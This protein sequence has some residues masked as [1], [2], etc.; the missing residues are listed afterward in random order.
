MT[1]EFFLEPTPS[2]ASLFKGPGPGLS[3]PPPEP[4][5][6][7]G[8]RCPS[9]NYPP[10]RVIRP[11]PGWHQQNSPLHVPVVTDPLA[12]PRNPA[13]VVRRS[14]EM[15]VYVYAHMALEWHTDEVLFFV[16]LS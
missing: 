5:G 15:C 9:S 14:R 3:S 7:G 10:D 16:L 6:P 12:D 13:D 2:A 4:C 8:G 11:G 1:P